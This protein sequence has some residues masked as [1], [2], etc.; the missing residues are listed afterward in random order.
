MATSD[1]AGKSSAHG[2][3][4]FDVDL[5]GRGFT[6]VE[7][8]RL[9]DTL[10]AG[11]AVVVEAVSEGHCSV[12]GQVLCG[13]RI[14]ELDPTSSLPSNSVRVSGM[15]VPDDTR[16]SSQGERLVLPELRSDLT[17]LGER[18]SLLGN[19]QHGICPVCGRVHHQEDDLC[20]G[21]TVTW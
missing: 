7:V 13:W 18:P 16:A 9:V 2:Q 11:F 10:A 5:L 12:K 8:E 3:F 17:D 15:P 19:S 6:E 20:P 4:I 1:N 21:L 14:W